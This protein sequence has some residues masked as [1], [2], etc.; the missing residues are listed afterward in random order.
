MK[1][2]RINM[3]KYVKDIYIENYKILF[4]EIKEDLNKGGCI[5]SLWS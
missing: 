5:S 1:D 3:T 2:F 4:R